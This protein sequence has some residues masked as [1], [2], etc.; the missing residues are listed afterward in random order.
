MKP[1][2]VV[3]APFDVGEEVT[4]YPRQNIDE[5]IHFPAKVLSVSTR[6]KRVTI[7]YTSGGK[8]HVAAVHPKRLLRQ[9]VIP[10]PLERL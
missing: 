3:P 4:Y 7:A 1:R 9:G 2:A 6:A 8:A 10:F 5:N